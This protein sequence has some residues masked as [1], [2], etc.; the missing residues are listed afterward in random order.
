MAHTGVS[1]VPQGAADT[2]RVRIR[3]AGGTP[4]GAGVL[5][6]GGRV[7]T[8]AHV[9]RTALGLADDESPAGAELAL[10]FAGSATRE[11]VAASVAAQGW[12]PPVDGRGDVAVL[13]LHGSAPDDCAPASLHACGPA[14]DRIVRVFGQPQAAGPGRWVR[15]QLVGSGG[16]SPD[17]V[18][19]EGVTQLGDRV[20]QGFSGAGAVDAAG[21]VLGIVVAEDLR[22]AQRTGWLIPVEAAARYCPS[23]SGAVTSLEHT[24]SWPP[25]A[26]RELTAALV[27]IPSMYD[28]QRRERILRDTGDDVALLAARSPVLLEDVRAVVA[29]CLQYADGID[30]LAAALR[31][32][33]HGSLPIREFERVLARL[34]AGGVPQEPAS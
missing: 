25:Q 20:Q 4:V 8:C 19:F 17:W 9:A 23:I 22:A 5:I 15:V 34:R 13:A 16:L 1:G 7:L 29:V 10:D 32:Y 18:Q 33:E 28:P 31:W 26:E 30:R 21:D 11:P 6:S 24:P 14:R 27:R 3:G 12:A 2:W